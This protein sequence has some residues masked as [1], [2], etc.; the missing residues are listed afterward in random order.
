[1]DELEALFAHS[2]VGEHQMYGIFHQCFS[3]QITEYNYN[4]CWMDKAEQ[5]GTLLGKFTSY[6]RDGAQ[7]ILS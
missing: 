4:L 2:L 1:L 6:K 5:S 3:K 7:L